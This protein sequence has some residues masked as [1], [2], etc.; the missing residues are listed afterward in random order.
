MMAL[1]SYE[2]ARSPTELSESP[3]YHYRY[4]SIS[5]A[6]AGLSRDAGGR[7]EIQKQ[8]QNFC[9]SHFS[10]SSNGRLVLQT[11]TSPFGKAHSP[12]LPNR[13]YIAVPNNVVPGN[14]PL[15]VGY[16]VSFVNVS[17]G[18]GKWSL[19]LSIERVGADQTASGKALGQLNQ[20]FA[21]AQLGLSGRLCLNTLDSKYGNA[22]YLA[23]AF[24]HANLVN[25]TRFRA[26]MKIWTVGRGRNTKGAPRIYG[27][28]FY[29]HPKSKTKTYRHPKTKQP[30]EVYQRSVFE[31]PGDEHLVLDGQTE[32]GRKVQIQVW[33]WNTLLIRSKNGNNMKDKP[34]DLLAI[35]VTDKQTGRPLFKRGMFIAINGRRKNEIAAREGY[36]AYRRRYDIEPFIR[37][38]KQRLLLDKLQTPD[39]GHFDNWLLLHQPTAWLLYV[40]AEEATFRPKKWRKYLPQNKPAAEPPRL[41]IAQTRH[42]AQ[43]LFLTFDPTPFK[44]LKSKKGR[45]RQKGEKQIQR[46]RYEVVKKTTSKTKI[47]L[48]TEKIE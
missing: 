21:H 25:L 23:P 30:C 7:A 45:P 12:T 22:A 39:V 15:D 17:D 37:F 29:L 2:P 9:F 8:F 44:P 27:E 32:G 19:P 38:S 47:K 14:K 18:Q 10:P 20:L 16:E 33:R 36:Q 35:N 28:K 4:G 3:V 46:T 42:A 34:F 5:K 31:L 40:A 24:G 1:A 41:S 11:D 6:I 13:T 48:K 26:G 43:E